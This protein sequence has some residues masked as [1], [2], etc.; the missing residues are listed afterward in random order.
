MK[1]IW[2]YNSLPIGEIEE[3]QMKNMEQVEKELKNL[4]LSRYKSIREFTAEINL[5]YSTVDSILK[6]GVNKAGIN[7]IITI[8]KAL[9]I[10]T[11]KL[12]DGIIEDAKIF[13]ISSDAKEILYYYNLL[14]E[15]GKLEAIKRME[16]LTLINKYTDTLT[17]T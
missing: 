15:T 8:C 14:N 1:K 17:S 16:E 12:A 3:R 11:E 7:T 13:S 10:D 2:Q 5:P 4:I 6:R 9:N